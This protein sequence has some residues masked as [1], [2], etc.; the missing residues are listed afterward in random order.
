LLVLPLLSAILP[1]LHV[2]IAGPLLPAAPEFS[3]NA[4]TSARDLASQPGP[5]GAISAGS[6]I[7]PAVDW[8][9]LLLF[10]WA[11]GAAI[12]FLQIC[13]GWGAMLRMRRKSKLLQLRE[14]DDSCRLLGVKRTVPVVQSAA[15]SMPMT[16]GLARPALFIPAD[17][18]EWSSER[19]RAVLLHEL[20]H[21]RRRDHLTHVA[22]RISLGLYWWNPLAWAAW[23]E[24]LKEREKAADDVVLGAGECASSYGSHLLEIAR[25][26][27]T[28][29]AF[30]W[31]GIAAA[32]RSQLEGRLLSILDS[33]RNRKAAGRVAAILAVLAALAGVVPLAAIEANGRNTHVAFSLQ[34]GANAAAELI[35]QGDLA[36][37]AGKLDEARSLYGKVLAL[38]HTGP[39]AAAALIRLG[40]VELASKQMEQAIGYFAQ[41]RSADSGK[42]GEALMWTA[43]ARE[44][45]NNPEAAGAFFQ[46]ALAAV[47][48]G[49]TFAAT[50]MDLYAE[51]LTQQGQNEEARSI[52]E[53][54]AEIRKTQSAQA[55]S[56]T[57]SPDVKRVGGEVKPPVLA[58][59][60]EPEYTVEARLA[61]YQGTIL[62]HIEVDAD[63]VPRNIR[64]LRGLGL[65]LD[66]RAIDALNQWR[67]KPAMQDGQPV[68]VQARVEVNFRLL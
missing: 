32:R 7:L 33:H 48:P 68:T 54:A 26:L 17:A 52:R 2:S 11:A 18:I 4:F 45:Q 29:A 6:D 65:G 40:T 3:I 64:I 62:L 20:A 47:D 1:V 23:R 5:G 59:K 15:G 42:A 8:R 63:G 28:R 14:F 22:A 9:L 37:E 19:R 67:F 12:S 60:T 10:T 13:I 16:H 50:V 39:N 46:S 58:S 44:R 38:S 27:Q 31:A 61:Q 66:Q 34:P 57:S 49:S 21:V 55:F 24:F 56:A 36:R 53:R 25:S 35:R 43:I 41:A 30:G 51:L